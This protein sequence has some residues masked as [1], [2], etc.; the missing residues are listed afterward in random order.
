MMELPSSI[1]T[2]EMFRQFVFSAPARQPRAEHWPSAVKCLSPRPAS[3]S[4]RPATTTSPPRLGSP[5]KRGAEPD[6]HAANDAPHVA[7][8]E[9]SRTLESSPRTR[10]VLHVSRRSAAPRRRSPPRAERKGTMI[11][12][13]DASL[14]PTQADVYNMYR[15]AAV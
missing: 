15:K 9:M 13:F 2:R 8:P 4:Y 6:V 7:A 12:G 3:S 14:P 5:P 1:E 10:R 11:G